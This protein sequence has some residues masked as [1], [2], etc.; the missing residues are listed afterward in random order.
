M[1]KQI[2]KHKGINQ[3]TGR[4]NKGYKY[5]GK[6]SKTGL[7]QIVNKP[8]KKLVKRKTMKG[9]SRESLIQR[10]LAQKTKEKGIAKQITKM[11]T[12]P[13][14]IVDGHSYHKA[15]YA[16]GTIAEFAKHTFGTN[17]QKY[18][19]LLD[20][21]STI[22]TDDTAVTKSKVVETTGLNHKVK[23]ES[24]RIGNPLSKGDKFYRILFHKEGDTDLDKDKSIFFPGKVEDVLKYLKKT[25]KSDPK[26][27]E[28]SKIYLHTIGARN[29]VMWYIS[30]VTRGII[31]SYGS[32]KNLTSKKILDKYFKAKEK[33]ITRSAANLMDW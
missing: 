14:I 28:Y 21:K 32:K 2:R 18:E 24:D 13:S 10:I 22:T 15:I 16:E 9:G 19:V 27:L 1:V 23:K 20:G 6:V 8:V 17:P 11:I 29:P 26:K 5:S 12:Y 25:Q 4:L 30:L 33:T 7:K 31:E 3:T